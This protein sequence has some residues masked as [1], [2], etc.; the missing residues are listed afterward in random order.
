ME[1]PMRF[2]R[3]ISIATFGALLILAGCSD[4]QAPQAGFS[5]PPPQVAVVTVKAEDVPIT[6]DL[7]G[8]IA[9]TRMAEPLPKLP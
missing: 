5:F 7:P 1:E 9:A 4:E 3:P 6:N 8:R 2:T